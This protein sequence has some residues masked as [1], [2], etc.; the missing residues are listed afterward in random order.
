MG[1][2]ALAIPASNVGKGPEGPGYPV[3]RSRPSGPFMSCPSKGGF[4][5]KWVEGRAPREQVTKRYD[6]PIEVTSDP[7]EAGAPALFSWRGR[8]YEIDARLGSWREAGEWWNG[9]GGRDRE[10]F[11]VLA[12]PSGV[13]VDGDV[14]SDGFLT[15]PAGAVYDVYRDLS[16]ERWRLA[17]VWD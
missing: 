6:E 17:R 4:F 1:S 7:L 8:A 14:D 2:P 11:R 15:G 3:R 9:A 10:Y 12:R 16:A 5:S 13:V